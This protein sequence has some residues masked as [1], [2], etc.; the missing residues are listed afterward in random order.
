[1][2]TTQAAIQGASSV[3]P[4]SGDGETQRFKFYAPTVL[5]PKRRLTPEGFLVCEDVQIGRIGELLYVEGEIMATDGGDPLQPGRDGLIRVTRDESEVFNPISIASF[6]GKSVTIDH[7][8]D[9]VTPDNWR[10]HS[11]GVVFN[12]RRGEDEVSDFL[13]ADL[14]IQDAAAIAAIRA[15]EVREVSCGYDADYQATGLGTARQSN[16]IGNHVALVDKGRCGPRCAV[17]DS[18]PQNQ[19][20]PMAKRSTWDRIRTAFKAKDEAAFEEEL[21]AAQAEAE[22]DDGVQRLVIEVKQPEAVAVT[23]DDDEPDEG[24]GGEGDDVV[25][26]AIT[27]LTEAVKGISDRLDKIEAGTSTTDEEADPEMDDETKAK[28][29]TGDSA[30]LQTEF[31]DTVAR[32]EILAPGV[33]LPTFDAKADK[34]K[35]SD[36]LCGLRRKALGSAFKD[37]GMKKHLAPFLTTDS[38]DFASMS[39][40]A[41]KL[42]FSGASELAKIDNNSTVKVRDHA[43]RG[44]VQNPIGG[45]NQRNAEFWSRK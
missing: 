34:K 4:R 18:N 11:I 25:M 38:P 13:M 12:V 43:H 33:K 26:K 3:V 37:D 39:C 20:T 24:T 29:K 22:Q 1:M 7:P 16:I 21:E 14:F 44:A 31:T 32:A 8:D 35:T 28:S 2:E 45:I 41:V 6:L 15:N 9:D 40:E 23:T 17:R 10:S 36:S 27:S 42:M 5:G 30:G 19:E